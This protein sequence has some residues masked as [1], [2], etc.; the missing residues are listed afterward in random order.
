[1]LLA[2]LVFNQSYAKIM[3]VFPNYASFSE[4]VLSQINFRSSKLNACFLY[5][6]ESKKYHCFQHCLAFNTLLLIP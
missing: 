5:S 6:N 4:I 3:F 2:L 1:M